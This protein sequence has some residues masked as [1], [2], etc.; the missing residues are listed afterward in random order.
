M[1]ILLINF[2]FIKPPKV[3][4][5]GNPIKCHPSNCGLHLHIYSHNNKYGPTYSRNNSIGIIIA[6][7]SIGKYLSYR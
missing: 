5:L 2:F 3:D 4:S 1:F 7:G 6:C